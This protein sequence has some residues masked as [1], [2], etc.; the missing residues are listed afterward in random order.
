MF[1]L[2]CFMQGNRLIIDKQ[3][4]TQEKIIITLVRNFS[5]TE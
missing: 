5:V 4:S 1:R 2:F 3:T